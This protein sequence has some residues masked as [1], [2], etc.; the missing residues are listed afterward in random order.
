[1]KKFRLF[2]LIFLFFFLALIFPSSVAAWGGVAHDYLC[3]SEAQ[4]HCNVADDLAFK[5][6][7]PYGEINHLCL[8]NQPD[9]PPR[10]MAKYYLKKYYLEGKKDLNLL[11]AA[12]HLYQDSYCPDHW[13]PMRDYFGRTFA[14]FSPGWVGKT[15]GLVD[16]NLRQG[17]KDWDL[18]LDYQGQALVINQGFLDELKEEVATFLAQ[19]PTE[20]LPELESQI[21]IRNFL[22]LVRSL[23]ELLLLT[24][25]LIVAALIYSFWQWRR[26]K[27]GMVDLIIIGFILGGLLIVLILG[28]FY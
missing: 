28:L 25:V 10:L 8:D 6:N 5:K 2:F 23:R 11:G 22:S 15:E 4:H 3:P 19:E 17:K 20:S 27:K 13:F 9:C 21:K 1:M 7:Y 24:L 14:L 16:L 12:A 26:T 18:T